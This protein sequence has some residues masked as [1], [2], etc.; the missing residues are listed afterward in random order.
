MQ[1]LT[2][3][4]TSNRNLPILDEIFITDKGLIYKD[5]TYVTNEQKPVEYIGAA[6]REAARQQKIAE[7]QD[8]IRKNQENILILGQKSSYA[9]GRQKIV[10]NA[11]K[12]TVLDKLELNS[13]SINKNL[14][15]LSNELNS[16]QNKLD[17]LNVTEPTHPIFRT[18]TF[19]TLHEMRTN[20]MYKTETLSKINRDLESTLHNMENTQRDITESTSNVEEYNSILNDL[21]EQERK[22]QKEI[23][24]LEHDDY[25]G[26]L[27]EE[28]ETIR[29]KLN[30]AEDEYR[31]EVENQ[32]VVRNDYKH[33]ENKN[34][35]IKKEFESTREIYTETNASLEEL[36]GKLDTFVL[37]K[38]S[39]IDNEIL[40]E[41]NFEA[42]SERYTCS[43]I[44][45]SK[46]S[47]ALKAHIGSLR[48]PVVKN[49]ED[50]TVTTH[51]KQI[52]LLE[53]DINTGF[54]T[55]QKM[56]ESSKN[57]LSADIFPIIKRTHKNVL[58]S[59]VRMKEHTEA[60]KTSMLQFFIEYKLDDK[61]ADKPYAIEDVEKQNELMSRI[62]NRILDYI[63]KSTE[64]VETEHIVAMV[65]EELEPSEWYDISIEYINNNQPRATLTSDVVRSEFSTGER[66]RAY[67]TPLLTLIDIVKN[68]MKP[69]APFIMIMDEAFD[70]LDETQTKYILNSINTISDLFIVTV[71][72]GGLPMAEK[73]TRIDIVQLKKQEL[74]GGGVI[75]YALRN[76]LFEEIEND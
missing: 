53:K 63:N 42:S 30:Q 61:H 54:E 22:L 24:D 8:L 55:I 17:T 75:T 4:I 41:F 3:F 57:N 67:Y 20:F 48:Y 1:K 36:F 74:P 40:R 23:A 58:E 5:L 29:I 35:K 62:N 46:H 43:D 76:N 34:S 51:I 69:D 28:K 44:P 21:K 37:E 38:S 16:V 12:R 71:P 26:S 66:L 64:L 13:E 14:L 18:Y 39:K 72:K 52:E 2:N 11:P 15:K 45:K 19:S 25:Y 68:Q 70:T 10:A 33:E 6:A 73:T 9:K 31:N 50:N 7:T 47:E 32:I 59:I 49:R 27:L 65:L 60:N 56:Y